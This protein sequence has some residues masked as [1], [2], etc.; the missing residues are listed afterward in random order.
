M[1][2]VKILI[3]GIAICYYRD[4][5]WNVLI[6]FD[7]DHRVIFYN[8]KLSQPISLTSPYQTISVKANGSPSA[9]AQGSAWQN[10]INLTDPNSA[11]TSIKE[12][13]DPKGVLM[14]VEN[15]TF[16]VDEMTRCKYFVSEVPPP[17][18][19][20]TPLIR[21]VGYSAALKLSGDTVT[22]KAVGSDP[23]SGVAVTF[24]QTF[25]DDSLV[26]IDNTCP[27]RYGTDDGAD[28][29]MVYQ[30]IE[31]TGNPSR[32]FTIKRDPNQQ[33]GAVPIFDMAVPIEPS[34]GEDWA[35][36]Y[37]TS[38]PK[39]GGYGLPCNVVVA[40]PPPQ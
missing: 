2:K 36:I 6:P 33:P 14:Q 32:K 34:D 21:E 4:R 37:D 11:H 16:E 13:R 3:K 7:R 26:V 29:E 30:V 8:N 40:E 28:F 22:I 20:P 25:S 38:N 15:A 12:R 31:D 1:A 23:A 27:E 5:I 19:P 17:I 35:G 10:F 9:A 24:E 39:P 18:P